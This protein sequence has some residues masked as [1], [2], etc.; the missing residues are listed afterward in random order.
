[1]PRALTRG[2]R[3]R[4]VGFWLSGGTSWPGKP[5]SQTGGGVFP[6]RGANGDWQCMDPSDPGSDS[7]PPYDMPWDILCPV[8]L[9]VTL[10][11][12]GLCRETDE[13]GGVTG[14]AGVQTWL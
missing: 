1:M 2:Y 5:P 12:G 8:W 11:L 13:E 7:C 4:E 14:R 10:E 3:E 6:S 9:L